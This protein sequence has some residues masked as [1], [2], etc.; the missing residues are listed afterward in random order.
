MKE[1][2]VLLPLGHLSSPWF[3]FETGSYYVPR[4]A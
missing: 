4:L 1:E 2:P 3:D